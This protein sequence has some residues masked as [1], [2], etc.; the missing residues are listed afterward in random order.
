[1]SS[2]Y[3]FSS[4]LYI[5]TIANGGSAG[6]FGFSS[7][8][9]EDEY[10]SCDFNKK[11]VFSADIKNLVEQPSNC[12]HRIYVLEFDIDKKSI[13]AIHVMF[14][15]GTLTELTQDLNP[16]DTVVHLAD[17]SNSNWLSTTTYHRG[18][19]FW[20]YKNSYD[21]LY[22]PETYSRNVY[23]SGDSNPLW[24]VA[25][26]N[27]SA[28][29]ITLNSGWTGP[30][31]LSGTKV[32]RRQSGNT[33]PY[34]ANV[35][36]SDTNWHTLKG[37]LQGITEPGTSG[38]GAKFSQGTAFIRVGVYPTSLSN[39]DEATGK[40]AVVANLAVYEE[41]D[42]N[43]G[44]GTL[45]VN[46]G[47]TGKTTA[48]AAQRA[49]L[50]DMNNNTSDAPSDASL[51]F[52]YASPSDTSGAIFTRPLSAIWSWIKGQISSVLGL[53]ESNGVK[54][55]T[56]TSTTATNVS[57]NGA[58]S[59]STAR[60]IWFSDSATE[61]KRVHDDNFKYTPSTNTVSANVSGNAAT[62][63][64]A[65]AASAAVPGS[66]LETAIN[67]KQDDLGINS[68]TGDQTK[69]L[70][71]QGIWAVPSNDSI[72]IIQTTATSSD[73]D[74]ILNAG[75]LPVLQTGSGSSAW[76][77]Q[78]VSATSGAYVF[79]RCVDDYIYTY[80]LAA[81][82]WTQSSAQLAPKTNGST[83][84]SSLFYR[85]DGTWA[86]PVIYNVRDYGMFNNTDA[87]G[88]K[89]DLNVR[90]GTAE[91]RYI[92]IVFNNSSTYATYHAPASGWAQV[93]TEYHPGSN[94]YATQVAR[95]Y[96]GDIW[97]RALDGGTWRA[98]KKLNS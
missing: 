70:N 54:T 7:T 92:A 20:N 35:T 82:S 50:G 98:W 4:F 21:Y 52:K 64:T 48:K 94:S 2:N 45:P 44:F 63:T 85:E 67:G 49:L 43:D 60:H 33:Y 1:M 31:I 25:N 80:T 59:N 78:F 16:G 3:N 57:T 79:G 24:E 5:P 86:T 69:F 9:A 75:K 65:D 71:E 68:S 40:R 32:S 58:A 13:Q 18:F 15:V 22:P 95:F 87:S 62:A 55:F 28:G 41:Q 39:A 81:G 93:D 66:A 10:I 83:P 96:T 76:Y 51:V 14:G 23:P 47:G 53:S 89:Y 84:G 74:A 34:P 38:R 90:I 42:I 56:G 46:R 27:V 72:T 17:L 37:S 29:T 88:E 6:S 12:V 77:Y 36:A 97:Y 19:I 30:K 61:T 11:I 91:G 26:V 8:G 73:I